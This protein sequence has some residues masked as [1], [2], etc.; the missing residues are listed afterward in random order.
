MVASART[1]YC[2]KPRFS[3]LHYRTYISAEV[4]QSAGDCFLLKSWLRWVYN[5]NDNSRYE[6]VMNMNWRSCWYCVW[7]LVT[8]TLSLLGW[9]SKIGIYNIYH[10]APTWQFSESLKVSLTEL[11]TVLYITLYITLWWRC[12]SFFS[13]SLRMARYGKRSIPEY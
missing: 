8:I 9:G 1:L 5:V 3:S 12:M 6:P 7:L 13:L 2:I 11:N 10:W 4:M